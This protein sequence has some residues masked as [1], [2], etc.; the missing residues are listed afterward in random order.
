MSSPSDRTSDPSDW[1]IS[2][3]LVQSP[4]H[5]TSS[6]TT[7][8]F[9]G[10]LTPALT[11]HEDLARGNGGQAWPAGFVLA[12]YLLRRKRDELRDAAA[13]CVVSHPL[14]PSS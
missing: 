10:L 14:P 11:L 1:T 7:V 12:R 13:M 3:D 2:E 5:K 6:T 8:D 9:G 4:S